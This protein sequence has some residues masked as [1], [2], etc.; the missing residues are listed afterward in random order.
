MMKRLLCITVLIM[1]FLFTINTAFSQS[2]FKVAWK[3]GIVLGLL[4]PPN[5]TKE[6]LKDFIYKIRRGKQDKTLSKFL[7]PINLKLSD[8]YTSFII[9]I[10]SDPK[11]ATIEEYNKYEKEGM[12]SKVAQTYLNHVLASYWYDRD[13]REYGGLGH[14]DGVLKSNNYEKLF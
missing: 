5:T 9:F 11:W 3:K 7:P 12:D 13:D 6:Q 2:S 10:F 1:V 14:N 4:V 8:K